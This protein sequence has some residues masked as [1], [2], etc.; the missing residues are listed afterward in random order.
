[1]C[2]KSTCYRTAVNVTWKTQ[3][4]T[5]SGLLY[6]A[7]MEAAFDDNCNILLRNN[8]NDPVEMI[9]AISSNEATMTITQGCKDFHCGVLKQATGDSPDLDS[10]DGACTNVHGAKIPSEAGACVCAGLVTAEATAQAKSAIDGVC[11]TFLNSKCPYGSS[12]PAW[13][14]QP[15]STTGTTTITLNNLTAL[16]FGRRLAEPGPPDLPLPAAAARGCPGPGNASARR[17]QAPAPASATTAN[18]DDY[19]PYTVQAWSRCTCYQQ[20]IP[21]V[22]TRQVTCLATTCQE[23]KPPTQQ[24]CICKHCAAC[25]VVFRMFVLMIM[26]IVQSC[27]AFIL[28]LAYLQASSMPEER[29]IKIGILR[30]LFGATV[31]N[32]PPLV[33]LVVLASLTLTGLIVFQTFAPRIVS[34]DFEPLASMRDCFDS[35][36]LRLVSLIVGGMVAFQIVLGRFATWLTRKPPWL[37]VPDRA[38]WPTPIKQLRYIFRSLGP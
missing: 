3:A 19:E 22:Q 10:P 34:G 6:Q 12:Y 4:S 24:E 15:T 17:L 37:Y 2:T 32:L 38:N 23:P 30:K 20:C 18:N 31:K 29:F 11:G 35:G 21:G 14:T 28:F 26:F 33:R 16:G 7:L 5:P 25:S 13:C 36:D 8:A 9:S 27:L 1:M